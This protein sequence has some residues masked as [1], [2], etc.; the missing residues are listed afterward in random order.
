MSEQRQLVNVY[1]II[2]ACEVCNGGQMRQTGI[3]YPTSPMQ[4]EHKCRNCGHEAVYRKTYPYVVYEPVEVKDT[5]DRT[6]TL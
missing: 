4:Y 3:A 6:P 5:N 2:M 1:Q